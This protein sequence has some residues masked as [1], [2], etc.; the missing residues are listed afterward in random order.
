MTNNFFCLSFL[1]LILFVFSGC[2][3]K[4]NPELVWDVNLFKIGS[5][6][7]PRTVDLNGDGVL[8]IVIGAGANEYQKSK[9]G[10][11]ALDGK[12]GETLWQQ[13][14]PDQVYGAATFY[15]INGDSVKDVFIGGRSPHFKA[16]DGRSGNII[17]Q[18]K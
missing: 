6:S 14:S 11:L 7:S 4:R 9:Q 1:S 17:W 2:T 18:Y 15:D 5:Q 10:I 16:L 12:T 3:E 13:E 8:D